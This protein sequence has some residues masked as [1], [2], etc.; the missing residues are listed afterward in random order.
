MK[1]ISALSIDGPFI[2]HKLNQLATMRRKSWF[3]L[4]FLSTSVIQNIA[5]SSIQ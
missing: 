3:T 2:Q 4:T 5:V 1:I